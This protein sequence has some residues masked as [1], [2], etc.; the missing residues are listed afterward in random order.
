MTRHEFA[1]RLAQDEWVEDE[2]GK[3]TM[4]IAEWLP[5]ALNSA[6]PLLESL[7]IALKP[8]VRVPVMPSH[9]LDP[10]VIAQLADLNW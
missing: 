7:L 3:E 6:F 9:G 8:G 5:N 1:R 10:A 2:A 4:A